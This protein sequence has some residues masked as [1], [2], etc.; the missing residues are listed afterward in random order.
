[1]LGFNPNRGKTESLSLIIV[2]WVQNISNSITQ[3]FYQVMFAIGIERMTPRRSTNFLFEMGCCRYG[4]AV[5]VVPLIDRITFRWIWRDQ[6]KSKIENG[7]FA[8]F[9]NFGLPNRSL[10][11]DV[12]TYVTNHFLQNQPQCASVRWPQILL[13]LF[14]IWIPHSW[15]VEQGKTFC[16]CCRRRQAVEERGDKLS[17]SLFFFV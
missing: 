9:D 7:S 17:I 1:M 4:F 11:E 5:S 14:Q 13:L 2:S 6:T 8:G 12:R 10:R 16:I 15:D 3:R